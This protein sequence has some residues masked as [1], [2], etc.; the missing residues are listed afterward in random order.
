MSLE[1]AAA[2]CMDHMTTSLRM[3]EDQSHM[4]ERIFSLTLEIIYLL[5]GESFPPLKS[6]D[7]VTITVPSP[8]P[9]ISERHNK[10]KILEIT[11]KMMELLTGEMDPVTEIHQRDVQVLFIPRIVNR[12][13]TPSPTIISV[14]NLCMEVLW[15]KRKKKRHL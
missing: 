4:T 10:Q 6:G 11:R 1:E 7:H 8:Q 9:L 14:A 13:V 2:S 15:L 12:K 3:D 5:T